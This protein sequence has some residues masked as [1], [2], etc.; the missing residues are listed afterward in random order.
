MKKSILVG[1]IGLAASAATTFGQGS[2]ALNN[3][4]TSILPHAL[5]DVTY[6]AGSGGT[7]NA[8]I[9][10]SFTVGLYWVVGS[11]VGAFAADPT[12]IA[13]PTSLFSGTGT[14]ALGN[15]PG[16]TGGFANATDTGGALG[17]YAPGSAFNPDGNGG[18]TIT[19]EIIAYNGA[20]Y[21]SATVRGHSAAFTMVTA[22][23]TAGPQLSGQQ[24][25]DGGFHVFSVA[26]PEPSVLALSG[27]GG[28]L[29]MFIRRKKA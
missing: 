13:V 1:I 17:E 3:Y 12:G 2:I 27:L 25:T 11:Q 23:G 20:S 29:L 5:Q 28:A 10:S 7:L 6:G 8:G 22:A 26:V 4:S 18:E 9:N 19:L 21:A 15:G 14:L 24:E 16:A